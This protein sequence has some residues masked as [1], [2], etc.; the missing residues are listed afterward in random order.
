[1]DG[2]HFISLRCDMNDVLP[3]IVRQV[4]IRPPIHKILDDMVIAPEGREVNRP[5]SL[6]IWVV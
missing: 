2:G 1:M 5:Q 3:I 6:L 4:N